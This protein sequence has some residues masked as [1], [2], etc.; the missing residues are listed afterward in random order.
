MAQTIGGMMKTAVIHI[1]TEKTGT[2]TIQEFLHINREVL[3]SHG[4]AFLQSPGLRNNRKLATY[5]MNDRNVD[6][7]VMELGITSAEARNKWKE[8][9]KA[10][11][12]R[13][14]EALGEQIHT[15]IISSEHFHSRLA[16]EAEIRNLYNLLSP[17]FSEMKIIVY[18]RRQDRVAVSF[19]STLCKGG[20]KIEQIFPDNIKPENHYYNYFNLLNKWSS[21]FGINNLIARIFEKNKL[22]DE[23]L[24]SDFTYISNLQWKD[25]Q[26]VIPKN[27]NQSI[28]ALTQEVMVRFNQHFPGYIDGHPNL[29]ARKLRNV[30]LQRLNQ[31]YPSQPKKPPR[32]EAL[33]FY[34]IFLESNN[35]LANKYFNKSSLFSGDFSEYPETPEPIY[36]D[37]AVLDDIFSL[38]AKF[39]YENIDR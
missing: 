33:G 12:E 28:S 6:D 38:F 37:S 26:L 13:E 5:C 2:T 15:V 22:M 1:G 11:L 25:W 34:E 20:A 21:I 23:D 24:I 27:E 16:S 36:I 17:F 29:I 19:Y 30:L 8:D 32:Q 31:K 18:L 7:H 10:E 35:R 4:V 9:F 3:A 14:I 39:M